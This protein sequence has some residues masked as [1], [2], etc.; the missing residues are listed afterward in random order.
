MLANSIPIYNGAPEIERYIN[1]K[2]FLKYDNN[3]IE[4]VKNLMN[5]E[6]E[7]NKVINTPAINEEFDD[8][9]FMEL[10][11]STLKTKLKI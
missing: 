8:E 6:V 2:R 10:F 4:N 7:Y 5:N 11:K 3:L 9:N 1:K